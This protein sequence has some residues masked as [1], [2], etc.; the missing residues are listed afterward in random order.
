MPYFAVLKNP[1][2]SLY[3]SGL[4]NSVV[5]FLSKDISLVK[6]GEDPIRSYYVYL[7]TDTGTDRPTADNM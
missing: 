7:L 1:S 6:F 5:S 3:L 4:Q 2:K